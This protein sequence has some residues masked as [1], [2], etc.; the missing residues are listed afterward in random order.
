[1]C[2]AAEAGRPRG[3]HDRRDRPPLVRESEDV[4]ARVP[5]GGRRRSD[6]RGLQSPAPA[7]VHRVVRG[8]RTRGP[9]RSR[10]QGPAARRRDD[11]GVRAALPFRA[12]PAP[13]G[14]VCDVLAAPAL[15][16]ANRIPRP[17]SGRTRSGIARSVAGM[18]HTTLPDRD[19][20]LAAF[21]RRDA[22]YEGVF[23][24]AVRTTGV[25]CR[26]TCP[27]RRPRPENVEFF[28]SAREALTAG[29]RPCLR[30][31]P[32]EAAGAVP[33][34]LRPLLAEVEASP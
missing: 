30:C 6:R 11:R 20:M 8:C 1:L 2:E 25:F 22:G 31:R 29:Y 26:P 14:R 34:W 27:A 13:R 16:R 24:T 23:V 5:P 32:L 28:T 33:E 19:E 4:G 21:E 10:P 17:F 3:A 18:L 7:G 15:R 12:A 9:R